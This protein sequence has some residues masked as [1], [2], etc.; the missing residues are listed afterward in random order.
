M[1][2]P[3]TIVQ[4]VTPCM[5]QIRLRGQL[6]DSR[7]KVFDDQGTVVAAGVAKE[8]EDLV[9]LSPGVSLQAGQQLRAE[10]ETA[11]DRS[12]PSPEP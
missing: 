8:T 3:P 12:D 7:V 1:L 4:P 11:D 9:R 6:P 10:Q 5:S 2:S